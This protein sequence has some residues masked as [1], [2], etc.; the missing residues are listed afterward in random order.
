MQKPFFAN[1]LFRSPW[2]SNNSFKIFSTF[3]LVKDWDKIDEL[4]FIVLVSSTNKWLTMI[5]IRLISV[6]LIRP[7]SSK[8][9]T[10]K[11]NSN[12]SSNFAN[13]KIIKAYITLYVLI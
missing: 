8:S 12:L 10:L 6:A 3:M 5:I 2:P 4:I 13:K 1:L 7:S 9:D 11:S